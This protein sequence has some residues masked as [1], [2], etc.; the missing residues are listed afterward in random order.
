MID[1]SHMSLR[2]KRG[3][4]GQRRA[5]E[6]ARKAEVEAEKCK[7]QYEELKKSVLSAVEKQA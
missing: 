4:G 3:Q 6:E 7:T 1:T 5:K 2:Q